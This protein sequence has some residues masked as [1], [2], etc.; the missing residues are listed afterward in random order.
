VYAADHGVRAGGAIALDLY[1]VQA[2]IE[3]VGPLRVAG[4]AEPVSGATVLQAIQDAWGDS[5]GGGSDL[6]WHRH[7]KDFMGPIAGA[8]MERLMAG[9]D[10][11]L[12]KVARAVKQALDEKHLLIYLDE[13]QAGGLLRAGNWD[14]ALP[15]SSHGDRL[16]VVD[17]NVG[18]NK[19]DAS[20]ER[21]IDY[22]VDLGAD[23]GPQARLALTYRNRSTQPLAQ[24]HREP[25]YGARYA[26]LMQGCYWAYIRVYVPAGS[27][28]LQGP[29]YG[30]PF[31]GEPA[32]VLSPTLAAGD[33]TVWTAF[34]EVAPGVEQVVTFVYALPGTVLERGAAGRAHYALGVQKQPGTA[35]VPLRVAVRLPAGAGLGSELPPELTSAAGAATDLRVDRHFRVTYEEK[36]P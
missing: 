21:E 34:I 7:R 19:V 36:S 31:S 2:L 10:V 27:R 33:W 11:D 13:P 22:R 23:G 16:M 20:I 8:A 3:A 4:L 18:F 32:P 29:V 30:P 28:L 6:A 26:D 9:Q 15:A 14:G 35:A 12:L 25:A 17:S 1:A 24:C 5:S